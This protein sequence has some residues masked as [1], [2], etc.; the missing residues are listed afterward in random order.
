MT[1][2]L[3]EPSAG[4]HGILSRQST[5][6]VLLYGHPGTGKTQLV[7]AFAKLPGATCLTLSRADIQSCMA[8]EAEKKIKQ[9]FTYARR[10]HPCFITIDDAHFLFGNDSVNVT[11][12]VDIISQFLAE[13]DGIRSQGAADPIVIAATSRPYDIDKSV[14]R[15]LGVRIMV[16]M[17]DTAAREQLLKIHLEGETLADDVDVGE[18]AKTTKGYTGC[19]IKNLVWTAAN[20]AENEIRRRGQAVG[21]SSSSD[22]LRRVLSRSDFDRAKRT[23][24]PSESSRVSKMMEFHMKFGR[25]LEADSECPEIDKLTDEGTEVYIFR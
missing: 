15:R 1:L 11:S 16:D 21:S 14:L 4:K 10:H 12:R 13:M 7:R 5:P 17:P 6:G 8:G 3:R 2:F 20:S 23:I 22:N 19:D 25:D 18:L 9:L 24:P